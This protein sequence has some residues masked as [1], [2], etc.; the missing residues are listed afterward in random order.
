MRI[1]LTGGGTGGHLVPLQPLIETLR[2]VHQEKKEKLPRWI[3]RDNLQIY[4]MGVADEQMEQFLNDLGVKVVKIPAGKLRRY[5]SPRTFTDLLFRLPVGLMKAMWQMW[6]VMPDVVI[7]KGG[8]GSLPVGLAATIYRVPLLLHESDAV[9][10]LANIIMANWAEVITVGMPATRHNM[11]YHKRKTILTGTPVRKGLARESKAAS[12]RMFDIDEDEPVLLVMGGSQGATKINEMALEILPIILEEMAVIHITGEDHIE[13]VKKEARELIGPSDRENY[14]KPVGYLKE[15]MG[16]ALMAAD[17]VITRAGAT[18]L[19]E[20]AHLRKPTIIIPL[21]SSA[22]DH[23]VTNAQVFE[24]ADAA[25]LI[26]Q[27][28]LG[29][30]MLVQNIKDLMESEQ[31]RETL[32]ANIR[33]FDYPNAARDIS[34]IAFK[35]AT[36]LVPF[37]SRIKDIKEEVKGAKA[38]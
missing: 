2:T 21:P 37:Q 22:Q 25:R 32:S 1:V 4:F 30:T 27:E 34:K 31:M 29:K 17:L 23:Q 12:K 8:Y 7:S 28:N 15:K 9:M 11:R 38:S 13:Q 5:S 26:S 35:L 24:V 16:P 3:D 33:R 6:R 14:Y 36:G 18:S 10:G 19:A 20:L